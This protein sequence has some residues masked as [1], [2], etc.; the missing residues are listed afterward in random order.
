[1]KNDWILDVLADLKSFAQS[2]GH[3]L[4]AEQLTQARIVATVEIASAGAGGTI[5]FHGDEAPVGTN[6]RGTG[7]RLQ[8]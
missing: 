8:S 1:M 5:A 4:L 3:V 6:S 2:N 7:E